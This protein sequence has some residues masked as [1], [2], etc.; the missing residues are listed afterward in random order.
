MDQESDAHQE[1]T[2]QFDESRREVLPT[3]THLRLLGVC[4]SKTWQTV[5]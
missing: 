4:C 1:K 2:R 3:S 5:S